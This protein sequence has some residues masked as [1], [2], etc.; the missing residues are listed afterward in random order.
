MSTS[1]YLPD[2]AHGNTIQTSQTWDLK[3]G[4]IMQLADFYPNNP[5]FLL[6]ILKSINEQIAKEP[7][8]YFENPCE[9]VLNTFNPRSFYL[10][11]E[12]IAVYF[13]QYD[14]APYSSGIRVF[15]IT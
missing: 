9:L 12:G 13:Q 11:S 5:Y 7:E 10:I 4:R 1:I 8:I 14:I 6:N 2:G 3:H 15:K